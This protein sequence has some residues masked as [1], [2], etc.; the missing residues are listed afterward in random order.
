ME[1]KAERFSVVTMLQAVVLSKAILN[2]NSSIFVYKYLGLVISLTW[3]LQFHVTT[4]LI[5]ITQV[6]IR[7][8]SYFDENGKQIQ[9]NYNNFFLFIVQQ[10][11]FHPL[12]FLDIQCMQF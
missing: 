8:M 4:G 10:L 5:N 3:R 1:Q 7:Q 11:V 12:N 2:L 6:I 9:P